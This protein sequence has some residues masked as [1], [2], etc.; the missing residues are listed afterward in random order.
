MEK[1][2]KGEEG[3]EEEEEDED[4]Y[5]PSGKGKALCEHSNR[6]DPLPNE[7]LHPL[8]TT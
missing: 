1:E 2:E 8:P 3:G 4:A 6:N 5:L 7:R